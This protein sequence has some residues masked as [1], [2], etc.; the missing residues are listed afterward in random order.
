MDELENQFKVMWA[1]LV[2][3]DD[4]LTTLAREYDHKRHAV[5][6][7]ERK[8]GKIFDEDFIRSVE[9]KNNSL[10]KYKNEIVKRLESLQESIDNLEVYIDEL[11][12]DDF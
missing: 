10:Q 2:K 8:A 3:K 4:E 12:L 11:N 5:L 7:P 6:Y 9:I 1:K